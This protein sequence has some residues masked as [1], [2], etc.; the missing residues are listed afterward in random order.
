MVQ[1]RGAKKGLSIHTRTHLHLPR[2]SRYARRSSHPAAPQVQG[3]GAR[4]RT[5]APSCAP[6]PAATA[7]C[8]QP[9]A[10]AGTGD[11]SPKPTEK[12]KTEH[13]TSSAFHPLP[14]YASERR[15]VPACSR[16][17]ETLGA[18]RSLRDCRAPW[19]RRRAPLMAALP[20]GQRQAGIGHR[21]PRLPPPP[22]GPS[23]TASTGNLQQ[24][25]RQPRRTLARRGGTGRDGAGTPL[26]GSPA[27][28]GHPR[29]LE[30][31]GWAGS[32]RHVADWELPLS[33]RILARSPLRPGIPKRDAGTC[34]SCDSE[35]RAIG[36]TRGSCLDPLSH[37]G[38]LHG[39][40]SSRGACHSLSPQKGGCRT[41]SAPAILGHKRSAPFPWPAPPWQNRE[42]IR[43]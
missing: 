6:F 4:L 36:G 12:K 17:Q 13:Q 40:C 9:S 27:L 11:P 10:L 34:L 1:I 39:A 28:P 5:A 22:R 8:L 29:S 43:D 38:N 37:A 15:E 16:G 23:G 42:V 21:A 7:R 32:A 41:R 14:S 18:E 26:K 25:A 30:S 19:A 35:H 31:P 20:P 33:Y 2:R 24:A 3:G